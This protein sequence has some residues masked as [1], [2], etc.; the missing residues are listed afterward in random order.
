MKV[1]RLQWAGHQR[2]GNNETHKRVMDFRL[3]GRTVQRPKLWGQDRK[4]LCK[5]YCQFML[6]FQ[7][8][9]LI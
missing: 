4:V 9:Q 2:M 1:A 8:I 5:L 6:L 7:F 3:K